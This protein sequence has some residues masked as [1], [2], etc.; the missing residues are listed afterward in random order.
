MFITDSF[1]MTFG[2]FSSLELFEK[3]V[4]SESEKDQEEK[5][6]TDEILAAFVQLEMV[7]SKGSLSLPV[8]LQW[9]GNRYTETFS[10]PPDLV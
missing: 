5:E 8:H 4:E 7:L 9:P 1:V 6:Q 2:D 3:D 10:P